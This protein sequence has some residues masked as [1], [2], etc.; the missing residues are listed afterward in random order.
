MSS[1]EISNLISSILHFC[2]ISR[3]QESKKILFEKQAEYITIAQK[4]SK[5]NKMLRKGE[6]EREILIQSNAQLS[7]Y[8][9][10]LKRQ[11][12]QLERQVEDCLVENYS[13]EDHYKQ[14]LQELGEAKE[15][16][17]ELLGDKRIPN[18]ILPDSLHL[19]TSTSSNI[20]IRRFDL[21]PLERD[22]ENPFD[23]EV[24]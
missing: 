9:K 23:V 11:E 17:K 24:D 19:R 5:L 12:E 18:I 22:S 8:V 7:E 15:S 2:S 4:V 1:T 6:D 16:L 14:I 3:T 21:E 10:I 20:K 13:N